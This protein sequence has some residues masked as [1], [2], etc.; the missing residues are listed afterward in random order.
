MNTTRA[1][2]DGEPTPL[3]MKGIEEFNRGEFY[4]QHETLETAWRAEPRPVRKLYQGILQIGVAC[5]HLERGNRTGALRLLERGLHKL[6]PFA[7]VCLGIDVARLIADAERLHAQTQS[8]S[9]DHLV[10]RD[11]GLFPRIILI[12]ST[13]KSPIPTHDPTSR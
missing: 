7:P 12:D 2:C 13:V 5:Y 6:R 1:D 9:P 10:Q 3:V 4:E 11:R 8:V